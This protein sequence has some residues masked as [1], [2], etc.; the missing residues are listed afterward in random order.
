MKP[1]SVRTKNN[2]GSAL[3]LTGPQSH[4]RVLSLGLSN[5]V[6]WPHS[7]STRSRGRYGGCRLWRAAEIADSPR[8][9]ATRNDFVA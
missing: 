3:H 6:A 1:N 5:R 7:P 9:E 2:D 4:V 8:L